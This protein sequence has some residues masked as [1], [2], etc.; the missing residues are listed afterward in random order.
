MNDGWIGKVGDGSRGRGRGDLTGVKPIFCFR[1]ADSGLD[2]S[3]YRVTLY[4]ENLASLLRRWSRFC[5]KSNLNASTS[6]IFWLN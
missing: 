3:S 2:F 6:I 5:A 1:D 4:E